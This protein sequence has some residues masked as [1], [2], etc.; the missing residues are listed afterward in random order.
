MQEPMG[1]HQGVPPRLLSPEDVSHRSRAAKRPGVEDARPKSPDLEPVRAAVVSGL[2]SEEPGRGSSGQGLAISRLRCPDRSRRGSSGP[3]LH[4]R[5]DL[6]RRARSGLAVS[7]GERRSSVPDDRHEEDAALVGRCLDG[8]REAWS[9]LLTRHRP[10]VL[11]VALRC[12]LRPDDAE[13]MY[14]D[15]CLTLLERLEL[16]RDHRSLA[17]WVSTTTARKCWKA[18]ARRQPESLSGDGESPGLEERLEDGAPLPEEVF[19][20]SSEQEAVRQALAGLEAPCAVL[21]RLLFVEDQPYERVAKETGL[22]VGSIGVYR[23]RCLERLRS[24][25]EAEGWLGAEGTPA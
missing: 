5:R 13:E 6:Q 21:L 1:P 3:T 17:A 25:L 8:D 22:A 24:R 15:V 12:G 16:L 2:G 9:S 7:R 19:A 20:E 23:R 14:Q 18:R 11:A 10:L 4:G